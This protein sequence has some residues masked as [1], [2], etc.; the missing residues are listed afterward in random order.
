MAFL[1][2]ETKMFRNDNHP[3]SQVLQWLSLV[4][5]KTIVAELSS[6]TSHLYKQFRQITMHRRNIVTKIIAIRLIIHSWAHLHVVNF[7]FLSLCRSA[8]KRATI[9]WVPR[10]RE[11]CPAAVVAARRPSRARC[12][13]PAQCLP[14]V[15]A[16]QPIA[17]FAPSLCSTVQCCFM[18][19]REHHICLTWNPLGTCTQRLSTHW[20]RDLL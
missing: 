19:S 11:S 8:P 9:Q 20:Y 4:T 7:L 17:H 6:E 12:S 14:T 10:L 16:S 5:C 13:S 1:S 18:G 15:L 3:E 2:M